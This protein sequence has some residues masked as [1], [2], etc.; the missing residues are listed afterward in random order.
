MRKR[1]TQAIQRQSRW[2]AIVRGHQASGQSVRAYCRQAGIE[3][4]A[5]YWWRRELA[6]RSEERSDGFPSGRKAPRSR[7]TRSAV[8]GTPGA[9]ADVGFLPVQVAAGGCLKAGGSLELVLGGE[10][11]LRI[12]P[13][14]DRQTLREVLAVLEVRPC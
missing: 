7:S 10:R 12:P 13:G 11:V 8:R 6:R 1:S 5:F 9:M 4:S 14:F 2:Q 3:E